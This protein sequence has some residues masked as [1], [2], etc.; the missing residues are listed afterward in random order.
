MIPRATQ[1]LTVIGGNLL[2]V[3]ADDLAKV[4]HLRRLNRAVLGLAALSL[5]SA[6]AFVLAPV[7]RPNAVYSWPT[8]PGDPT[9]AAIPLMTSL[10][11]S[12]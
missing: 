11:A 2:H 9:A 7:E 6:L 4:F 12:C 8:A 5:V 10:P 3:Q 1:P